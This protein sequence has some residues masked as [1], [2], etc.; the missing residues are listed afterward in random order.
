MKKLIVVFLLINI[1]CIKIPKEQPKW[2]ITLRC[3]IGDSCVTLYDILKD[4]PE[5]YEIIY[6]SPE[7]DSVFSIQKHTETNVYVD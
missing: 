6:E 7:I 1:S 2:W 3:P 5:K 4:Q